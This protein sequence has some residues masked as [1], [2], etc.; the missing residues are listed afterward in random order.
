MPGHT[1]CSGC[2]LE[3]KKGRRFQGEEGE[4]SNGTDTRCYACTTAYA[5]DMQT[6]II[7]IITK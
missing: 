1:L 6:K 3:A 7:Q 5:R 2:C 4:H